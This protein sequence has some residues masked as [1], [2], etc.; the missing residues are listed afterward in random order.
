MKTLPTPRDRKEFL[1]GIIA[2]EEINRMLE[3][4]DL[5]AAEAL[6]LNLLDSFKG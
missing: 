2:N 4:D 1:T 6:A 3:K 5:V